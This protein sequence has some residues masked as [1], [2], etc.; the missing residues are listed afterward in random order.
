DARLA[1]AKA[2]YA[3]A[4]LSQLE[5]NLRAARDIADL[6]QA[7]RKAGDISQAELERVILEGQSVELDVVHARAELADALAGCRAVLEV[8][9]S[10]DDAGPE[11]LDRA[12]EV[13][14]GPP[15][16]EGR[17]DLRALEL[18]R[19]SALEDASLAKNR[20]I[21]DPELG[22]SFTRDWFTT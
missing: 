4:H 2:V 21:P 8:A 9:C 15:V 17:A 22:V 19:R 13:P 3:Q 6:E 18:Q 5:E 16:L 1:L 20:I 11:L 14:G 12:A 7:R 10:V